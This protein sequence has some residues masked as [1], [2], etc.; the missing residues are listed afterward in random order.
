M[1]KKTAAAQ[2]G[3]LPAGNACQITRLLSEWSRAGAAGEAGNALLDAVYGTL[4]DMAAAR[5]ASARGRDV[6]LQPTVLVH[7]ALLRMLGQDV[8]YRDRVHFF[9]L[10]ALKM[11]AVLVDHARAALAQKRGGGAVMVTLSHVDRE[12]TGASQTVEYQVLALHVELEKFAAFDP[13]AARAV[14]LSYFGG[15]THEEIAEALA[16]SVP[17]VERDLRIARA[18]LKRRLEGTR[19]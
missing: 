6:M 7:E 1:R 10:A 9:S 17:T 16:V 3:V 5:L 8:S 15:M 11:R 12:A 14:E 4:R 19:P 2:E 13:R 18:W